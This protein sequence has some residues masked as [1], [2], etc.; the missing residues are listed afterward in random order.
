VPGPNGALSCY[1]HQCVPSCGTCTNN[2]DCCPGS[3]CLNGRCDPC[4]GGGGPP[5]DSGTGGGVPDA[6][7]LPPDGAAPP[8]PDGGCASYGQLCTSSAVCCNGVPCNSGR[9]YYPTQ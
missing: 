4:G 9:C 3:N 7:G 8:P 5:N 6:S 1:G 2:A